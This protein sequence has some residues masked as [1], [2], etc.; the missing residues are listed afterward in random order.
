MDAKY[1]QNKI[2]MLIK[3]KNISEYKLSLDLAK[4]KGYIQGITSGRALPSMQEFLNICDY[5]EITP[6]DFFN[7]SNNKTLKEIELSSYLSD[8]KSSDIDLI[9]E[10]AKRLQNIDKKD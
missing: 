7:T 4:S 1:I 9:I 8:L 5:F 10:L 3:E 6:S 2:A